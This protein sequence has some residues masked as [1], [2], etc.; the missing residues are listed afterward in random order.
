MENNSAQSRNILITGA[1][2][3][4]G[5]GL[6]TYFEQQGHRLLLTDSNGDSLAET[7]G[8]LVRADSCVHSGVVDITSAKQVQAFID[9][10][11]KGDVDVLINNAGTQ[12]VV[13]I[14]D[15][16]EEKWDLLLDVMLKGPFLLSKA[17]LPN[18]RSNGFGRIVNI[19]SFHSL[20]ASPFKSAYVA[21]K[22][23]LLGLAKV[24]ALETA[25]S[26]ITVN[27]ICPSY[28][29]TPLVDAQIRAQA[30]MHNIP[31]SEVIEKIMLEPMPKKVFITP[32][33]IA[34]TIEFLM[35]CSA[36]NITG[37]TIVIDGGW[38]AR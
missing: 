3:G 17:V 38:T 35:S 26:D 19:G 5:R 21:A 18:M 28:I 10:N 29:K 22:H 9:G 33:E 8:S 13:P 2:G 24:A 7:I 11:A 36:R 12:H 37:Q 23:G 14:E 30:E 31:E 4:L 32:E 25:A 15:L 1:G 27:T 34:A 20:V 6:A 16:S